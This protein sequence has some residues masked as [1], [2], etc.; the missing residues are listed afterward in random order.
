[1]D[2]IR[3]YICDDYYIIREGLKSILAREPDLEVVGEAE[4]A[5]EAVEQVAELLPDVVIMDIALPGMDGIQATRLIKQTNPSVAVLALTRYDDTDHIMQIYRSGASAYLIKSVRAD[6][7]ISAIRTLHGGGILLHPHLAGDVIEA[8]SEPLAGASSPGYAAGLTPSELK[9]LRLLAE[10]LSNREIAQRLG[11]SL[12]TVQNHLANI[13]R[14]LQ[15][16][17]RI[18]AA[19]YAVRHGIAEG[20][21]VRGQ[22]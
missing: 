12:R 11:I 16:N 18:S 13:F 6:E 1:M 9:V 8:F 22:G 21:S 2:G 4:T 17:D 14:K 5:E 20:V 15:L 19:V 7:L 3:I 10:G